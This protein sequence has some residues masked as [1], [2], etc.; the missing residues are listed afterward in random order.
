MQ[1]KHAKHAKYF[2]LNSGY[3]LDLK[4]ANTRYKFLTS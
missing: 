4:Y 2:V 1:S 3:V